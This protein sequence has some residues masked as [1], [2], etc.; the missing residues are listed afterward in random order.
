MLELH[1]LTKRYGRRTVLHSV[2]ATVPAGTITALLGPNGAGK[3]TLLH[4]INGLIPV[5]AGT[6]SVFDRKGE[7][8]SLRTIGFCPDDLPM[9]DLLTGM[10]YLD[11]V[12]GARR[13]SV[14]ERVMDRL[15]RGMRLSDAAHSLIDTYS[16]GMRRKLQLIAALLHDPNVLVLDEPIRG[17]DPESSAIMKQLLRRYA[18]R[19]NAV[20]LS[21]HDL[22]VADQLCDRVLVLEHGRLRASGDLASIRGEAADGTLETSFLAMTGLAA[23]AG[24][25][26]DDFFAGL[27]DL[28]RPVDT[29]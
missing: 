8:A 10:E 3:S 29:R 27:D 15:L 11:L 13:I 19:G 9:A 2:T 20:L 28:A 17:L 18:A 14:P 5:D 23:E 26:A 1:E 7:P 21:T 16:H 4:A 12:Q 25:A 22:M 6:V 24:R